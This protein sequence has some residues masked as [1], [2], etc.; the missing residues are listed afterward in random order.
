MVFITTYLR[1]DMW[2]LKKTSQFKR[3]LKRI[4]GQADKLRALDS[5][6]TALANTGVVPAEYNPHPLV[7]KWAN[8]MEC[9]IKGDFLLIWY[10]KQEGVISLVRLGSHSELFGK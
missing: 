6:L 1:C 8:Y 10:D 4:M 9:H 2:I 3:D 7:G 5:V